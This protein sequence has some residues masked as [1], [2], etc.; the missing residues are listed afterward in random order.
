MEI[1]IVD[2]GSTDN[3]KEVIDKFQDRRIKYIKLDKN[4][5][6]SNARNIGI[7]A[8]KGKYISFQDSDDIFYFIKNNEII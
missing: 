5:G 2:D 3:T 7:K 6:A 4:Q 8:A 1:I